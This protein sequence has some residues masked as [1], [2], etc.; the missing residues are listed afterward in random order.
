MTTESHSINFD[1]AGF[2]QPRRER[3]SSHLFAPLAYRAQLNIKHRRRSANEHTRG[4]HKIR[5]R[6]RRRRSNTRGSRALEVTVLPLG[7]RRE[8]SIVFVR[9]QLQ[10]GRECRRRRAR[11]KINHNG[12]QLGRRRHQLVPFH[13]IPFHSVHER[14]TLR[15]AARVIVIVGGGGGGDVVVVAVVVL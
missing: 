12:R 10:R 2:G 13:S 7:R 14:A 15:P 11:C 5:R 9:P 8:E 4:R 1:S 6:R 3:E